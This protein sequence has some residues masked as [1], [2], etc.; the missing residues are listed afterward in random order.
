M[1]LLFFRIALFTDN[2]WAMET[3]NGLKRETLRDIIGNG[4]KNGQSRNRLQID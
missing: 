3:G 1:I 4:V 2:A